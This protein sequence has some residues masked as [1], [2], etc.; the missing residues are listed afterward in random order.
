MC[1][2]GLVG[3]GADVNATDLESRTPLLF[4]LAKKDMK[5]LSDW[6]PHMN[7]VS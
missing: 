4:V 6:T 1:V 3:Y 5:P 2:E 7:K